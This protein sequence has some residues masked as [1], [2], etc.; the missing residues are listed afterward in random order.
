MRTRIIY[1]LALTLAAVSFPA[2][3]R[4]QSYRA[5]VHEG[6]DF[7]RQQQFE[8]AK[9][10]YEKSVQ[11]DSGRLEGHFNLGNALYRAGDRKGAVAQYMKAIPRV[12]EAA[13]AEQSL[14]NIGNSFLSAGELAEK[15]GA[16][17]P[18]QGAQLAMEAYRQAVTAYKKALK[19]DAKD[20]NARYNLAYAQR[21]LNQMENQQQNKNQDQKKQDQQQK[22]DQQKQD[23]QKNDRQN[24][25]DKKQQQQQ[26]NETDQK[27]KEQEAQKK[28]QQ[29]EQDK[30]KM[31]KLEAE[32]ILDALKNDEKNLQKKLRVKA[33][34]R[35]QVEK[36]W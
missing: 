31:S 1:T 33:H 23:Q 36:D 35:Y 10:S 24:T 34:T 8:D 4:A 21:K 2:A 22:Q 20:E 25:E 28:P 5:L 6:N 15:N 19:V 9:V 30:N 12:R 11:K 17:Q 26:E 18:G 32:R 13:Q 7:Y 16:Q 14:Y 3:G 29:P 27:G